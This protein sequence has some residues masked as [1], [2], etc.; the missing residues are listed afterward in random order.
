MARLFNSR[1]IAAISR[2]YLSFY[3]PAFSAKVPG[4][5][6]RLHVV[7]YENLVADPEPVL[8]KLRAF[9]GVPLKDYD[10]KRDPDTGKVD[11]SKADKYRKAWATDEYAK[12]I[13][14]ARVGSYREVLSDAEVATVT[15][16]CKAFMERFKYQ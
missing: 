4:F 10:P 13:T 8:E 9:T 5:R 3:V 16:T 14:E 1:D 11:Y 7:R 15:E 12:K 2:H 6:K